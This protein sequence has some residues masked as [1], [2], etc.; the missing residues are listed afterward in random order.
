M[1]RDSARR[2]RQRRVRK[3]VTGTPL[4]PRLN[5]FRSNKHIYAQV[6]DDMHGETLAA[7]SSCEKKLRESDLSGR[8]KAYRVGEILAE[9]AQ[10]RNVDK[11]VFDR[12]GYKFHGQV[13][14]LAEG[15]RDGGLDL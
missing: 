3:K 13:K 4:R 11:V 14:S 2:R 7:A 12:A 8:E 1:S 5:V 15:A 9:R 6:I 10:Q